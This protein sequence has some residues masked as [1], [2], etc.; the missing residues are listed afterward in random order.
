[1]SAR[2]LAKIYRDGTTRRKKSWLTVLFLLS[3]L[4]TFV[5]LL[6]TG[7]QV[8]SLVGVIII[9]LVITIVD[10]LLSREWRRYGTLFAFLGVLSGVGLKWLFEIS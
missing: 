9:P 1:M 4:L 7:I 5:I 10:I 8:K 6:Q 2:N 3:F